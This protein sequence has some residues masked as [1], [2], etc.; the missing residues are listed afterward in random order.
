MPVSDIYPDGTTSRSQRRQTDTLLNTDKQRERNLL[1]Q[2]GAPQSEL[3]RRAVQLGKTPA[4]ANFSI[5]QGRTLNE[6]V[7]AGQPS[8]ATLAEPIRYPNGRTVPTAQP[9]APTTQAFPGGGLRSAGAF[10]AGNVPGAVQDYEGSKPQAV[11]LL[12][13]ANP[14]QAAIRV[15]AEEERRALT[16]AGEK[17]SNAATSVRD[18]AQAPFQRVADDIK[19]GEAAV[20]DGLRNARD[21]SSLFLDKIGDTVSDVYTRQVPDAIKTI[22]GPLNDKL[23]ENELPPLFTPDESELETP[24]TRFEEVTVD[25]ERMSDGAPRTRLDPRAPTTPNYD[26]SSGAKIERDTEYTLNGNPNNR[27]TVHSGSGNDEHARANLLARTPT[28]AQSIN[29]LYAAQQSRLGGDG[30]P[31]GAARRG[32][33]LSGITNEQRRARAAIQE[34]ARDAARE[35]SR[36]DN[37]RYGRGGLTAKQKALAQEGI[38]SRFEQRTAGLGDILQGEDERR[39]A[40]AQIAGENERAA[41]R[42]AIDQQRIG[43]DQQRLGLD[44]QRFGLDVQKEYNA[45]KQ[46]VVDNQFKALEAEGK[47]DAAQR[48]AF[49]Q[50]VNRVMNLFE[51]SGLNPVAI[52]G[53][54][55]QARGE[56]SEALAKSGVKFQG[57]IPDRFDQMTPEQAS[58][59]ATVMMNYAPKDRWFWGTGDRPPNLRSAIDQS[60]RGRG[61]SA[62]SR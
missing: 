51:Q 33:D 46:S 27:F 56:L 44:Q 10:L 40:G 32:S 11:E 55:E 54:W 53:R 29:E 35:Q 26:T 21:A 3:D 37:M 61:P 9:A 15:A 1:F 30:L 31:A 60:A 62:L 36:L 18:A 23:L 42:L 49:D 14:D 43:I 59:F 50:N 4:P 52:M 13:G 12:K 28:T 17:L 57:E 24:R 48:A 19:G 41:G 47:I 39:I 7:G 25:A 38:N 34:A 5:K 58:F 8:A 2:N 20:R 45:Q 6:S 22:L 16:G